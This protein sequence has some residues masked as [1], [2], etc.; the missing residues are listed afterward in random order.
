V[1]AAG[2][3][4]IN[5]WAEFQLATPDAEERRKK[6]QAAAAARWSKRDGTP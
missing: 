5:G 3:W 4:N 2:G 6:A 1:R